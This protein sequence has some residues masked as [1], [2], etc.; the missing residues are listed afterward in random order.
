MNCLGVDRYYNICNRDN[1]KMKNKLCDKGDMS[2]Y[3]YPAHFDVPT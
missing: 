1:L 2:C 3:F